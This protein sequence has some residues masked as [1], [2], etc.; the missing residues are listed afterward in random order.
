MKRCPAA[1]GVVIA[2]SRND[3]IS[4]KSTNLK[5]KRGKAGIEPPKSFLTAVRLA[6]GNRHPPRA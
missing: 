2:S 3:T 5:P 4:R 6:P 1:V